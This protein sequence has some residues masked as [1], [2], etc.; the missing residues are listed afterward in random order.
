MMRNIHDLAGSN[1]EG[2]CVPLLQLEYTSQK[3]QEAVLTS[4]GL[5]PRMPNTMVMKIFDN[6]FLKF[7]N[8]LHI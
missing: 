4:K 5:L 8:L 6:I 1:W 7:Y 2:L 3:P